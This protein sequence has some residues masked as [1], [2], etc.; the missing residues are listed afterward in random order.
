MENH[1]QTD[2]VLAAITTAGMVNVALTHENRRIQAEGIP[3]EKQDALLKPFH[4]ATAAA[5][6]TV[7]A[8]IPTTLRGFA[9]K[10][11]YLAEL[12]IGTELGTGLSFDEVVEKTGPL[13]PP[14]MVAAIA[15][16]AAAMIEVTEAAGKP[17]AASE[18]VHHLVFDL[19]NPLTKAEGMH[20]II[21][22][23]AD[24]G[25]AD[26]LA[27]CQPIL[28]TLGEELAEIRATFDALHEALGGA[29]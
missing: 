19:E 4:D 9:E 14:T 7:I 15:R 26:G 5:D 10:A 8:T 28:V 24:Y 1:T 22:T 6:E 17:E 25:D 13:G 18:R 2:P 29:S 27:A 12:A 3:I 16:D 11:H 23:V 20:S 21:L